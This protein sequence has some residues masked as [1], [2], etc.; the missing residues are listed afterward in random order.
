MEINAQIQKVIEQAATFRYPNE[1]CGFIIKRGKR[2]VA[3]EVPNESP[4]PKN[5]FIINPEYFSDAEDKGEILAVWH[6]HVD[7]PEKPSEADLAGCEA[8]GLPWMI[9]S[10]YKR[11]EGFELSSINTFLPS[12]YEQPFVGR[13]YIYGAFDCWSLVVDYLKR[14]HG[15]EI[16]NEYPRV[17]DFWLQGETNFFDN[18][19]AQEGLIQVSDS[20]KDGDVLMFQT[21]KS[22]HANHV[23]VY[24][25]DEKILHHVTGRLST[26]DVYGGYW[27]KH[28]IRHLRHESKC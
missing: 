21:D 28:T 17:K 12:G 25:G 9:M 5:Y 6:T 23:A 11:S 20:L 4:D 19:F 8:S 3:I 22:G 18:C 27:E 7:Q 13:P 14:N 24:I 26:I 10:V 2:A 15:I 1:A 16:S